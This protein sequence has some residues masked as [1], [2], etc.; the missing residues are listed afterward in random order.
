MLTVTSLNDIF[1]VLHIFKFFAE[2][3]YMSYVN[4]SLCMCGRKAEK[5]RINGR[6]VGYL[7]QHIYFWIKIFFKFVNLVP[8]DFGSRYYDLFKI[9]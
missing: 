2:Y 8:S 3:Y 5:L 9:Y 4:V 6:K 7:E 1:L